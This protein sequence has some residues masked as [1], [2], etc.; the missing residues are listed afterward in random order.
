MVQREPDPRYRPDSECKCLTTSQQYGDV[1]LAK[2]A[3][4]TSR[5]STA[6]VSLPV[7]FV[8]C[9]NLCDDLLSVE[10]V[11]EERIGAQPAYG[12]EISSWGMRQQ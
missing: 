6:A 2:E 8:P 1:S 4:S 3:G 9:P 5:A 11:R 12:S 10:Y 7:A